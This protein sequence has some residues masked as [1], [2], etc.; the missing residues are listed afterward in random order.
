MPR[1][2]QD[3][4]GDSQ[5]QDFQGNTVTISGFPSPVSTAAWPAYP[6][7][8]LNASLVGIDPSV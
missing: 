7:N 6:W 4:Q 5:D 2:S 3:D 1:A 8:C